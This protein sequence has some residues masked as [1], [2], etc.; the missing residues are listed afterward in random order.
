MEVRKEVRKEKGKLRQI[1]WK[2][3]RDTE[4]EKRQTQAGTGLSP[5][6]ERLPHEEGDGGSADNGGGGG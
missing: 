6:P 2:E 1:S 3:W 5:P 4:E